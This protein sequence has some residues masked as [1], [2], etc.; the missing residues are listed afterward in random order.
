MYKT[1]NY[2]YLFLDCYII[3]A[4]I[5]YFL[6]FDQMKINL[7]VSEFAKK[8]DLIIII[9]QISHSNFLS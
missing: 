6:I 4:L 5:T 9:C 8:K 2:Y 1:N 7:N 3:N